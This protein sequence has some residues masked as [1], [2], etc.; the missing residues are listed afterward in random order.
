MDTVQITV[1]AAELKELDPKRFEK[2]YYEWCSYSPHDDWADFH[3]DAAR[4]RLAAKGILAEDFSFD[5]HPWDAIATSG[6]VKLAPFMKLHK[7]DEEFPALYIVCE[8]DESY[9]RL[10]STG[11][12]YLTQRLELCEGWYGHEASGVFAGLD[13][14]TW[15]ELVQDQTDACDLE[16]RILEILKAECATLARNLEAEYD[17]M[18][19]EEAFIESCDINGITFE[20]ETDE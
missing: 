7:L 20:L 12:R 11:G 4:E 6:C 8:Q 19:S 1:T 13:F 2:E 3:F 17:D 18:T 15:D 10:Y 5:S 14:E 9:A 16:T